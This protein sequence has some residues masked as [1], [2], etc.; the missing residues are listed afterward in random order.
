M[1]RQNNLFCPV[2]IHLPPPL[3]KRPPKFCVLVIKSRKMRLA[4]HA[5]G[6]V[7]KSCAY[8]FW[9]EKLRG[10]DHMEDVGV[11]GRLILKGILKEWD[12]WH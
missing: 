4:G 12:E 8:R 5:A 3:N 9:W 10:R 6:M 2:K 11:N 7:E 1:K